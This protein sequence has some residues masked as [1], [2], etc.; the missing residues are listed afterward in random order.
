MTPL[1]KRLITIARNH[2]AGSWACPD[3]EDEEMTRDPA[4]DVI[5]A[6]PEPE[7]AE[8]GKGRKMDSELRTLSAI[9]RQLEEHDDTAQARM[10]AYLSA[11]YKG[12]P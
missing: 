7:D 8:E 1:A 5:S 3:H 4:L 11:R 9:I 2:A 6:P 12:Q 10:M